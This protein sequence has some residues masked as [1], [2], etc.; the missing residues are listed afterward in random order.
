MGRLSPAALAALRDPEA[1]RSLD[2]RL[3]LYIVLGTIP[4]AVFGLAFHNQIE[5]GARDLTL[6]G[7]TLIALGRDAD[8]GAGPRP[9]PTRGGALL[10]PPLRA[11][12]GPLGPVRAAQHR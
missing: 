9:R 7:C 10:V 3:G 6:I 5:N 8:R 11:R 4:I 1:R 2:A 12:G